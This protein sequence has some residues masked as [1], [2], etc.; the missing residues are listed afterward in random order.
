MKW[1]WKATF[2]DHYGNFWEYDSLGGFRTFGSASENL[3]ICIRA[4]MF[5]RKDN[6]NLVLIKA[7]FHIGGEKVTKT[8][9]GD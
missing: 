5:E 1:Y 6:P 7:E 4:G 8:E 3:R 2:R 9:E